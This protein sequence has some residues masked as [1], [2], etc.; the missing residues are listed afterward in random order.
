[1]CV[2]PAAAAR[3]AEHT[4][5]CLPGRMVRQIKLLLQP[6]NAPSMRLGIC[7]QRNNRACA[8]LTPKWRYAGKFE[9]AEFT[10]RADQMEDSGPLFKQPPRSAADCRGRVPGKFGVRGR[11]K[12][13]FVL[14]GSDDSNINLSSSYTSSCGPAVPLTLVSVL[15]GS[16]VPR[17]TL[18]TQRALAKAESL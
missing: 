16:G 11:P 12:R 15:T 18:G 9:T 4:L 2:P 5:F 1:M 13:N 10:G 14:P 7:S 17:R 8:V 3:H 6:W